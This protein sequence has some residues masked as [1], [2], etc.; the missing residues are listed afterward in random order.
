[1]VNIIRKAEGFQGAVVDEKLFE[2]VSERD[3]FAAFTD[4]KRLALAHL[5]KGHF[6]EGLLKIASLRDRVD[7]FFDGVLVM[8][9]DKGVRQNRLA[10][11]G[12]IAELFDKFA[13]FSKLSAS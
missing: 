12:V 5:E 13:D 7:A 6:E 9:E 1:M 2:H 10:L 8:A 4:V 3:L 11:L